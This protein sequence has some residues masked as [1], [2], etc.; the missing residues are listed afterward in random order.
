MVTT[1]CRWGTG[2][3]IV[4]AIVSAIVSAAKSVRFGWHL[5][6]RHPR[7]QQNATNISCRQSGAATPG[8]SRSAGRRSGDSRV[9]DPKVCP[10]SPAVE[11]QLGDKTGRCVVLSGEP[12]GEGD[13]GGESPQ[14]LTLSR[15]G[16]TR[17]PVAATG[18]QYPLGESN[19]CFRT[20]N[21]PTR[22]RNDHGGNDLE[23][24]PE[25]AGADW[26]ALENEHGSVDRPDD[27]DL[28]RVV[29]SWPKLPQPVK[30][31]ILAMIGVDGR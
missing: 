26:S 27:S 21:Q 12:E 15:N 31:A 2:R 4:L 30:A 24:Q 11:R 29:E 6:H 25:D 28:R 5:R 1:S 14:T 17:R 22:Q 13:Q 9:S 18:L 20:E 16:E 19:P 3:Q 8:R 10:N 23:Q 7:W